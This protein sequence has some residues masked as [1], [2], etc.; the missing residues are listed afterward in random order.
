MSIHSFPGGE[1]IPEDSIDHSKD[2]QNPEGINAHSWPKGGIPWAALPEEFNSNVYM[3]FIQLNLEDPRLKEMP[4]NILG[5][6]N[7]GLIM[8]RRSFL[9]EGIE[10]GNCVALFY[11]GTG[12]R[13]GSL[14][15]K[16]LLPM[17]TL[18]RL[19]NEG[20]LEYQGDFLHEGKN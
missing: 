18:I 2:L 8:A 12:V 15:S 13:L 3:A 5:L 20:Q 11:D 6:E 10:K 1:K 19:I 16:V 14:D 17:E 7:G 4:K 9:E